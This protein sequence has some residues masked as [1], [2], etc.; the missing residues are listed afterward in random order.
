MLKK[1]SKRKKITISID[2]KLISGKKV[3]DG[4]IENISEHGIRWYHYS[5][6]IEDFS[7]GKI[8]IKTAPAKIGLDCNPGTIID[9]EIQIPSGEIINLQCKVVWS[10]TQHHTPEKSAHLD[11]PKK[12]TKIGMEIVDPP[13]QYKKFF[14]TLK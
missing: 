4:F 9:L 7:E 3:Y 2:A 1:R 12:Y 5:G 14:K 11:K 8:Y 6:T 13:Q 10:K